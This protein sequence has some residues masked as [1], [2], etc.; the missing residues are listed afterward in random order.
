MSK[1]G[2]KPIS[3]PD[4]VQIT[5]TN[6]VIKV[7]G[8]KGE[9]TQEVKGK[10]LVEIKDKKVFVKREND[11]PQTKAF[12]GLYRSIANNMI[13][14]VSKGFTKTLELSGTGYRAQLQGKKLSMTLGFSHPVEVEIPKSIECKLEGQNKINLTGIDKQEVGQIAAEIK[15]IRPAEPYQGKGIMYAG[16]KI[17]R[18]AGKAGK[19]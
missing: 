14:G 11:D 9:L 4:G 5:F 18:K 10:I 2:V 3:I 15:R 16:E 1:I 7:K 12:H 6:N 17:K 19:K 8:S 13:I